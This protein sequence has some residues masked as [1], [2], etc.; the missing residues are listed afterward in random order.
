M[1]VEG[2]GGAFIRKAGVAGGG[3]L[4]PDYVSL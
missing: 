1:A 4:L 2:G 3:A